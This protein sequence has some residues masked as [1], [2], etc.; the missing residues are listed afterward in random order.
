MK[1]LPGDPVSG[2]KTR[3]RSDLAVAMRGRHV[4]EVRALRTILAAI[5]DAEAVAVGAL[6]DKY[7]LKQFG[8]RSA[9]V[10]RKQLTK[11]DLEALLGIEIAARE[12][13][14]N[15]CV[16][17]NATAHAESLRFGI[18]IVQRYLE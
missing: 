6:H 17:H 16:D 2:L 3:L 15:E 14:A 4:D 7:A 10:P 11:A 5:D 8:D 1:E 9:E 18:S 13:A 12:A